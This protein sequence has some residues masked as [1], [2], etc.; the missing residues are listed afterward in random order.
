MGCDIAEQL[1]LIHKWLHKSA[2]AMSPEEIEEAS[3]LG[4]KILDLLN[5]GAGD[6][7]ANG[8]KLVAL[9]EAL[10]SGAEHMEEHMK[11]DITTIN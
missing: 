3:Q 6:G 1:E 2:Q 5:D 11:P 10:S 9:F 4:S 8:V 7:K